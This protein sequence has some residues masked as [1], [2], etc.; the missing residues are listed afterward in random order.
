VSRSEISADYKIYLKLGFVHLAKT[1]VVKISN[2]FNDCSDIGSINAF[3]I[4]RNSSCDEE[5]RNVKG[6]PLVFLSNDVVVFGLPL[7]FVVDSRDSFTCSSGPSL[8]SE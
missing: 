4:S 7:G 3:Q 6:S 1:R 5:H 8:S 2:T